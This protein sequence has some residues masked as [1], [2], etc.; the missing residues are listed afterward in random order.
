MLP[1]LEFGH[2][3]GRFS[4]FRPTVCCFCRKRTANGACNPLMRADFGGGEGWILQQKN[5]KRPPRHR[6]DLALPVINTSGMWR[7]SRRH[8]R[9]RIVV[10]SASAETRDSRTGSGSRV[11]S[12]QLRIQTYRG[13]LGRE[14]VSNARFRT[15]NLKPREYRGLVQLERQSEVNPGR[16]VRRVEARNRAAFRLPRAKLRSPGRA[17]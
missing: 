4:L 16:P 11:A 12:L 14:R 13:V 7:I 9:G 5:S 3:R 10:V 17:R 1:R 6:S 2:A 8:R 15:C